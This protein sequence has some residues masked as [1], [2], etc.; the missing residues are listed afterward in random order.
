M[1]PLPVWAGHFE[2][3]SWQVFDERWKFDLAELTVAKR[4]PLPQHI[5]KQSFVE[6]EWI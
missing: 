5:A 4:V 3:F 2:D 6:S 1:A